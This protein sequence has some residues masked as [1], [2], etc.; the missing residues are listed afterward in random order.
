M[1]TDV[2]ISNNVSLSSPQE[3]FKFDLV[4]CDEEYS[5]YMLF[6]SAHCV[7]LWLGKVP[8]VSTI[9]L[10]CYINGSAENYARVLKP[11]NYNSTFISTYT[12]KISKLLNGRQVIYFFL[13]IYKNL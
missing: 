7:L 13:I 8:K 12:T 1:A 3:E 4:I 10:G 2:K 11:F 9:A 5:G 6:I